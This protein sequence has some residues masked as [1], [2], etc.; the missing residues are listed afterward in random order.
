MKKRIVF[1][2]ALFLGLTGFGGEGRVVE[3]SHIN[4]HERVALVDNAPRIVRPL[5]DLQVSEGAPAVFSTKFSPSN[6]E[7]IWLD[8]LGDVIKEKDGIKLSRNNDTAIL[9]IEEVIPEDAGTY[10]VKFVNKDGEA[11]STARLFV[12]LLDKK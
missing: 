11:T 5:R 9:E 1:I 7:I 8:N 4:F 12:I 6:C 2:F 10:R 3:Q